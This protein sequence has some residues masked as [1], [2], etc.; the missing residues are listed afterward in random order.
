[1][2]QKW[3]YIFLFMGLFILFLVQSCIFKNRQHNFILIT[4]D[5]QRADHISAYN[6]SHAST[7]H[8]DS[9][10]QKG[11]LFENCFS[12]I[13]IT[14]PSHAS[15]FF[16]LPPHEI[17]NYNNGQPI[18]ENRDEPSLVQLLKKNGFHTGAFVSLGVLKS[19]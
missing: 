2:R 19:K 16:S 3:R 12:L 8:I 13:P 6:P 9:L 5:T 11:V 10:A 18:K 15:I 14:L 17:K 1:M 7:P 4:L